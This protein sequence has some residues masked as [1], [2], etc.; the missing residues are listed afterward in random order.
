MFYRESDKNDIPPVSELRFVKARFR[1]YSKRPDMPQMMHVTVN[2]ESR[3]S[4]GRRASIT[5]PAL[6]RE[7]NY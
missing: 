7:D 5:R 3:N 4:G 2:E 1:H 6:S